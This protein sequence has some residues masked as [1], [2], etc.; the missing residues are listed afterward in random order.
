MTLLDRK[1]DIVMVQL[2]KCL[3][4]ATCVLS[5]KALILFPLKQAIIC[6]GTFQITDLPVLVSRQTPGRNNE[7]LRSRFLRDR[8]Q[9]TGNYPLCMHQESMFYKGKIFAMQR[10]QKELSA[11]VITLRCLQPLRHVVEQQHSGHH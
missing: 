9:R 10:S 8:G 3:T 6:L 11:R 2:C 4:I 5:S 1:Q 7:L